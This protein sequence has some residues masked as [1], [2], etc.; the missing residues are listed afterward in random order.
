MEASDEMAEMAEAEF[1]KAGGKMED[2][3]N[4]LKYDKIRSKGKAGAGE[5]EN[6]IKDMRGMKGMGGMEAG[7]GGAGAGRTEEQDIDT[8]DFD[9]VMRKGGR[10]CQNCG[11]RS[12]QVGLFLKACSRCNAAWYCNKEVRLIVSS[13]SNGRDLHSSTI[14]YPLLNVFLI[15]TYFSFQTYFSLVPGR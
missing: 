7:A 13:Y 4:F 1:V 6:L 15:Q 2:F 12:T 10:E 11:T 5:M 14:H 3:Q 9:K 8:I